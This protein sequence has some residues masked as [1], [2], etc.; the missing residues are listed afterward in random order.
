VSWSDS[1]ATAAST[2]GACVSYNHNTSAHL[3]VYTFNGSGSFTI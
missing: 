2:T 1:Y 3:H